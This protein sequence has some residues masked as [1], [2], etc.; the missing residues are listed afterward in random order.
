MVLENLR[1][2]VRSTL[3]DSESVLSAALGVAILSILLDL[4]GVDVMS[5]LTSFEGLF[6]PVAVVTCSK[7]VEYVRDAPNESEEIEAEPE[8][9]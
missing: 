1:S 6:M 4:A 2:V 8:S 7:L 9:V 3:P 5:L